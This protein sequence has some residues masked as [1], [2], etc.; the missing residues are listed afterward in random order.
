MFHYRARSKDGLQSYC[1]NCNVAQAAD[2]VEHN[3]KR[4]N[5][6]SLKAYYTSRA[7]RL[8]SRK[9]HHAYIQGLIEWHPCAVCGTTKN[10]E[11]HHADYNRPLQ[12][13]WLCHTCHAA[14]HALERKLKR[15]AVK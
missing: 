4:K 15:E 13:K 11:M 12:V 6:I 1:S 7:K 2:W 14:L 5:E 8:C 9:A 3:R 10:L